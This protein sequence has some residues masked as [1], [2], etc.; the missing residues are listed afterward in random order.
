MRKLFPRISFD[1]SGEPPAQ[2]DP[3]LA[4]AKE[5]NEAKFDL[6]KAERELEYWVKMV[7]MLNDRIPRL[8]SWAGGSNFQ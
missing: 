1:W 5:L 2:P 3:Q 4:A 8:E 7:D 6:L